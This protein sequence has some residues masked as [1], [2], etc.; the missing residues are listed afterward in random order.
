MTLS[1][2]VVRARLWGVQLDED[3]IKEAGIAQCKEAV[4]RQ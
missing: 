1:D 2:Q 4:L 3:N